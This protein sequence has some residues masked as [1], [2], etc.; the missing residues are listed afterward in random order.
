[1]TSLADRF[2]ISAQLEHLQ[3]KCAAVGFGQAPCSFGKTPTSA[4]GCSEG[5]AMG[6]RAPLAA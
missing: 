1:M 4:T 2:S 3:A 6:Q 5:V